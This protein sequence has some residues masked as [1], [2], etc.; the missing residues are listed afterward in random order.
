MKSLGEINPSRKEFVTYQGVG[1]S[2]KGKE[3][4]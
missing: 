3:E 2:G 4:I 1:K